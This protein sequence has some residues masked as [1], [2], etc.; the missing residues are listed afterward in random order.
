MPHKS[1]R[2]RGAKKCRNSPVD[3]QVS[4]EES[5]RCSMSRVDNHGEGCPPAAHGHK[6]SCA[7]MEEPTGQQQMKPEGGCNP[8]RA[9]AGSALG[10]SCSLWRG[11]PAGMGI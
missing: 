8:W 9:P 6:S 5:R 3:I 2:E 7:A 10:Q 1:S 11:E 4:I